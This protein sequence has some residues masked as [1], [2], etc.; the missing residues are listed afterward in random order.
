MTPAWGKKSNLSPRQESNRVRPFYSVYRMVLRDTRSTSCRYE[1]IPVS[2]YRSVFVN[3]AIINLNR[4]NSYRCK[5]TPV[6]APNIHYLR[7][8][9]LSGVKSGKHGLMDASSIILTVICLRLEFWE[10]ESSFSS[11]AAFKAV[12]R[13]FSNIQ[14]FHC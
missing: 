1:I 11:F 10:M 12:T 4:S 7:Y 9:K 5:F 2:S 14:A 13:C 8:E 3:L 6:A